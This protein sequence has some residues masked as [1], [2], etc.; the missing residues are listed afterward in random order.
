MDITNYILSFLSRYLIW[1][2]IFLPETQRLLSKVWLLNIA[3]MPVVD[4]PKAIAC[5]IR[6]SPTSSKLTGLLEQR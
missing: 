6:F 1:K 5:A 3:N 2:W 4:T